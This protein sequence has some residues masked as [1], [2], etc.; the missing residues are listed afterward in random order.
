MRITQGTKTIALINPGVLYRGTKSLAWTAP[1]KTGAYSVTVSATD[2][3]GN[4]ASAAG[5][6]EVQKRP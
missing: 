4:A 6:V 1:K 3:A 2:L 5:E